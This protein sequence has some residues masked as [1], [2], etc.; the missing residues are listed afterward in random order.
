M[1]RSPRGN[2][3]FFALMAIGT[4]D[5]L[6]ALL[7]AVFLRLRLHADHRANR[8]LPA[9]HGLFVAVGVVVG[10]GSG[11]V[12]HPVNIGERGSRAKSPTLPG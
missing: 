3:L 12:W 7:D 6:A 1:I 5:A 4:R 10:L 8:R 9:T 11:F 2:R